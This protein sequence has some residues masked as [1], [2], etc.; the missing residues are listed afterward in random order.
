VDGRDTLPAVPPPDLAALYR[1]GRARFGALAREL[2]PA[3]LASPVP[4]CPRWTVHD[5]IA[6]VAGVAEDSAAGNLAGAPGDEWTAR[7]VER[8]RDVPL[9]ELLARWEA[10]APALEAFL[11]ANPRRWAA[12][13]DVNAHEQDVRGAVDRPGAR[14]NA[15]IRTLVPGMLKGIDVPAPLV[16]RTEDGEVRV[17][18]D[19]G[20]SPVVLSTSRFEAFRWRL[21]RRS[22]A[23]VAAMDWSA[24]PSP[25]L[26]HLF[27]FGPSAIDVVE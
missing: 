18:P 21:G 26:D 8:G 7:H 1:E 11:A 12:V 19:S 3:E 13:L 14:D 6:H 10:G 22:R 25:Y 24:D 23:Q 2:S 9:E 20:E 4:A 17:G 15:T 5:V 16:V 27:V